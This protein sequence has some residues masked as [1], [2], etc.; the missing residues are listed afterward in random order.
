MCSSPL[1]S[2]SPPQ[3]GWGSLQ[4]FTHQYKSLYAQLQTMTTFM[5]PPPVA[6]SLAFHPD[7][8]NIIAVGMDD[9]T[10][11]IYNARVDEVWW[12][13]STVHIE[14]HLRLLEIYI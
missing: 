4:F 10:I 7:D 6:T 8:N 2:P 3:I 11:H 9:S 13:R 14:L 5:C 1:P 12:F